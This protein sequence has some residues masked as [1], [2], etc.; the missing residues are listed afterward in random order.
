MLTTAY[1]MLHVKLP[2]YYYYITCRQ[3]YIAC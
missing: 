1:C 3:H 2:C